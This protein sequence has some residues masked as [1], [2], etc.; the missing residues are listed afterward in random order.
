MWRG[1]IFNVA[2]PFQGRETR[3]GIC[4]DVDMAHRRPPRLLPECYQGFGRYSLTIS[5]H[6]RDELFTSSEYVE[7]ATVD[8]L[9]TLADYRFDGIAY[10]FMPDHFHGLFEGTS[11]D[12][13]VRKFVCMFKQRSAFAHKR[14]TGGNLWQDG[15]HDRMRRREEAT[16]DVVAYILENPVRA[17]LCTDYRQY[18]FSGSSVYSMEE[19]IDLVST[20]PRP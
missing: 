12:S 17:G 3:I 14:L 15:Y 7:R 6:D 19:L 20:R 4:H 9:R 5:S 2:R 16:R 1:P 8:L 13:D 11:P 18:P 10:C